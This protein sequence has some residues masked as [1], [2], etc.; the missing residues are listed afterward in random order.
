MSINDTLLDRYS[1]HILM[2]EI[3]EAGQEKLHQATISCVG[4]G[5]LGTN[6]V[7]IL[8]GAGIGTLRL[9][10]SDIVELSNLPR[11]LLYDESNLKSPKG[12]R[13]AREVAGDE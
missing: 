7:S 9:I 3:D 8:A 2:T 11:Q 13:R 10:D 4:L 5:G 12:A 6:A 1:R